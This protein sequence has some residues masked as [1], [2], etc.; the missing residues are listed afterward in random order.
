MLYPFELQEAEI[1]AELW[2]KL[3]CMPNFGFLF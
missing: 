3:S 1:A 2:V